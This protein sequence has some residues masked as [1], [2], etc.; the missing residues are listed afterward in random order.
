MPVS[1]IVDNTKLK[2]QI[3]LGEKHMANFT[4]E[5]STVLEQLVASMT[6]DEQ[7]ALTS[8]AATPV[9]SVFG[10]DEYHPNWFADGTEFG[11]DIWKIKVGG[12]KKT[13]IVNF[14]VPLNDDQSL[15]S[16]K[17]RPL[18]NAFKYWLVQAGNPLL[19]GG[20]LLKPTTTYRQVQYRL[21]LID[22]IL[23]RATD[24]NLA[25][26]HMLAINSDFVQDLLVQYVESGVSSLYLYHKMIREYILEIIETV[27]DVDAKAFVDQCP[28][29]TRFIYDDENELL[30]TKEQIIKACCFLYSKG[31]YYSKHIGTLSKPKSNYF[32]DIFY[33]KKTLYGISTHSPTINS[34]AIFPDE[35]LVEYRPVPVRGNEGGGLSERALSNLLAAFKGLAVIKAD[36][37]SLCPDKVFDDITV[38]TIND[39]VVVRSTGRYTTLPANVV[40][41]AICNAFDFCFKYAD[42]ILDSMHKV[43][44]Y[45][46][47]DNNKRV[48]GTKNRISSDYKTKGFLE[49]VS[50]ELKE[51]GVCRWCVDIKDP[52]RFELRRQNRGFIN[53]YFV[54]MGSIQLITGATMARRV[55]EL[56]DL[57]PTDCLLPAG[58]DPNLESYA[59]E[60][61]ELIFDNRK[62]GVGGDEA[63]RE[64]LSRPII[65]SVAGLLYKLERFNKKLIKDKL[66]TSKNVTLFLF[67]DQ[68]RMKPVGICNGTYNIHID[69]FCD[70][71][72][73][74]TV[75][76]AEGDVRRY[77]IRQ[78]QLRRFFAMIF[79]WRH[80]SSS[81]DS[82]RHFLGHTDSEHLYHYVTEE[83]QGEVLAG[84]KARSI[85]EGL[86]NNDIENIDKLTPILKERY[87]V[88][89]LKL[90]G[91]REVLSDYEHYDEDEA[92]FS[93][94]LE[95]I[96][97]QFEQDMIDFEKDITLLLLDGTIELEPEFIT[98]KD[99]DDNIITD[100]KLILRVTE[101]F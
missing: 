37:A 97:E 72:E 99:E 80:G 39:L 44:K 9:Q 6:L 45:V 22:A 3:L 76:Y 95:Q 51:L 63:L 49:H 47:T 78:H 66:I 101:E 90:R 8:K 79:F 55:G 19:N 59:K 85:R 48:P 56:I 77:Y 87:G 83:L 35:D 67:I 70:Y 42:V 24:I 10:Y 98:I 36:G 52:E 65:R 28:Y 29:L 53:L 64:T 33:K 27:S 92:H 93:P 25:E 14:D 7:L 18:L 100:Y 91:Y 26:R 61:F 30:L 38:K 43:L 17:H 94:P 15:V 58:I 2:Q 89:Y 71:F 82:I 86:T 88:D 62:S 50:P 1:L 20:K 60:K 12:K 16:A 11:H 31:V 13:V 54:L 5:E 41:F 81:L 69:A 4:K 57:H 32:S 34:L 73:T 74:P 75:L 68:Q 84:V 96:Q 23:L 21:W 46:P 40:F